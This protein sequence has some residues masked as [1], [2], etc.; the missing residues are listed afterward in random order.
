MFRSRHL[1]LLIILSLLLSSAQAEVYRWKD[2]HG[3]INFSD[4]PHADAIQLDIKAP[5]AAGIGTSHEQIK[6]Q[7]EMLDNFQRKRETQQK[8]DL[9]ARKQQAKQERNCQRLSDRLR[10]YQEAD[11]LYARDAA[12]ERQHL[13]DVQKKTEIDRLRATID[14]RC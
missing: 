6:R 1:Y 13:T 2:K 11:Y 9:R 14:E 4:K 5:K 7:Q 3:K 12:G 10:N 8:Q